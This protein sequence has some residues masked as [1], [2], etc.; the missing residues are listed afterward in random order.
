[1]LIDAL[2]CLLLVPLEG[3]KI[4]QRGR[5]PERA[6]VFDLLSGFTE[7]RL[8]RAQASGR[9]HFR[10]IVAHVELQAEKMRLPAICRASLVL[11]V[12]NDVFDQSR[13]LRILVA[14]PQKEDFVV[15]EN[16]LYFSEEFVIRAIVRA[17]VLS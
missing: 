17:V 5:E 10:V 15:L 3:H 12:V 1:M 11:V 9:E 14:E 2:I 4:G 16:V 7:R 6:D 13:N 8:K